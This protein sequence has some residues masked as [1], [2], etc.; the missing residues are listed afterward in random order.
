MSNHPNFNKLTTLKEYQ[1]GSIIKRQL[2]G[3]LTLYVATTGSATGDGSIDNPFNSLQTAFDYLRLVDGNN[4]D[5]TINVADGTYSGHNRWYVTGHW[6][7]VHI[8]GND[9]TPANVVLTLTEYAVGISIQGPVYMWGLF[10]SGFTFQGSVPGGN[11]GVGIALYGFNG[12]ANICDRSYGGALRFVDMAG[13]FDF[14]NCPGMIDVYSALV[15]NGGLAAGYSVIA[16]HDVAYFY[17]DSP[18]I[19]LDENITFNSSCAFATIWGRCIFDW[20]TNSSIVGGFTFTGS[21]YRITNGS[22]DVI[23]RH[24]PAVG[25]TRTV[26]E[27]GARFRTGGYV[28]PT[29]TVAALPTGRGLVPGATLYVSNESGGACLA[30]CDGTNWRRVTDRAIVS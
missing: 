28:I 5:L 3:P 9:A 1:H 15:I 26:T 12:Y 29:S 6:N 7:T 16:I 23:N 30:F 2:L 20:Y 27:G 11:N 18:T 8:K 14:A 24:T 22:V 13:M 10:I 4:Q 19:T 21:D 25:T 17:M